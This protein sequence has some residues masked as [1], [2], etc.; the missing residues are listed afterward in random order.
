MIA[1]V[2]SHVLNRMNLV[3][4]GSILLSALLFGC[5]SRQTSET[6][7]PPVFERRVSALG[8]IQPETYIRKV[9]VPGALTSDRIEEILVKENQ[10][11][12]KGQPL[13]TLNSYESLK[14]AYD[15]AVEQVA[16]AQSK[17]DQVK[18]GAKKGEIRA[19]DYKIESLRRQ[20]AAERKTQDENVERCRYQMEESK[21]QF[22][23]HRQLYEQG[24]VSASEADRYLVSSQTSEKNYNEAVETRP[25]R[26][27][28]L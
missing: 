8:R 2:K 18:A 7:P 5:Q 15:E 19:Q 21:R 12:K 16:V 28:T 4:C 22:A 20:L 3:A 17:L 23:R 11:V 6:A 9:A 24:A 1:L 13:A 26:M 27:R 14:A 10:I 25:G